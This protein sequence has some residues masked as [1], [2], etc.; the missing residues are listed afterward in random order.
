MSEWWTWIV[1]PLGLIAIIYVMRCI[2][3]VAQGE[4]YRLS[5]ISKVVGHLA[6]LAFLLGCVW[7]V[8]MIGR[9]IVSEFKP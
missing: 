6:I 3:L 5:G 8:A 2:T 7:A 4:D 9:A 1:G